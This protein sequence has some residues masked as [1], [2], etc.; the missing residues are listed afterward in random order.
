M[1][2]W[3]ISDTHGEHNHLKVPDEVDMMI[4]AGDI[5]N[6]KDNYK[7][8]QE[9]L[10]FISWCCPLEI[11]YKILIAG[12]HDTSIQAGLVDM[13]KYSSDIIYLE[14]DSTVVEGIKIFG[15]PYTP[16]FH[17]WAFNVKRS[18]LDAYWQS[19]PEN[20]DILVTHGPPLGILDH[21]ESGE[22]LINDPESGNKGV[23]SCGDKSLLNHVERVKPKIHVFGHLHSEDHCFNSGTMTISRLDTK[24]INASVVDLR[25]N[26]INNGQI[27]E[28]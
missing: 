27:I 26:L 11:K 13:K 20:T 21:T 4:C 25:R 16:F 8:E 22:G 28:F 9:V 15:S 24:F 14:H 23:Y 5:G 2:I 1:K 18:K 12:N 10:N 7:N 3:L 17:N 19:I 6:S